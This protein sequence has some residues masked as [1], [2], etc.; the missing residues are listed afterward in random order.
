MTLF[1]QLIL[2]LALAAP[3]QVVC[4]QAIHLATVCSITFHNP[5]YTEV[6]RPGQTRRILTL[7]EIAR[8]EN[9]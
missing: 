3:G 8:W 4:D 6:I 9:K 7:I 1:R 2:W 5:T